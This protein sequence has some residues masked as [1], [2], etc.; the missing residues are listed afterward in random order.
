MSAIALSRPR[1]PGR[2]FRILGAAVQNDVVSRI[3]SRLAGIEGERY[4]VGGAVRDILL[5]RGSARDIDLIIENNDFE[6]H[7][8]LGEFSTP[9]RNRHGNCRYVFSDG[10]HID[11]IEPRFFYGPHVN[12]RE[13]LEIFDASVNA[14]GIRLHDSVVLDPLDGARDIFLGRVHLPSARW[15]RVEGLERAHL[16]VRLARL[17]EHHTFTVVN[18]ELAQRM[19]GSFRLE[20]WSDLERLNRMSRHD[21]EALVERQ[22]G[23]VPTAPPTLDCSEAP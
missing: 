15:A 13:V 17:L 16:T 18:L 19:S 10:T 21:I 3:L 11:A 20:Y 22:L 5:G 23:F 9:R 12:A 6:A 8:I 14:V 7:K 1:S 2:G 4:V